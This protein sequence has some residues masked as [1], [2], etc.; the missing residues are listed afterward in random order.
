M[1]SR[2]ADDLQEIDDEQEAVSSVEDFD[3]SIRS[4]G[5]DDDDGREHSSEDASHRRHDSSENG[6]R[7]SRRMSTISAHDRRHCKRLA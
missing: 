3:K 7:S 4:G 6:I 5:G 2:E 1:D